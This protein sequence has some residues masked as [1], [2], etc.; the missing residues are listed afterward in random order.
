MDEKPDYI[1][2]LRNGYS[3]S[4][5]KA[6]DGVHANILRY[7]SSRRRI[8]ITLFEGGSFKVHTKRKP[9]TIKIDGQDVRD[10][11]FDKQVLFFRVPVNETHYPELEILF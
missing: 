3:P 1:I 4:E 6:E 11:K 8:S 2:P 10:W 5:I 9:K 7:I